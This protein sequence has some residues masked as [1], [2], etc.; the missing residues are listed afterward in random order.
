MLVPLGVKPGLGLWLLCSVIATSLVCEGSDKIKNLKRET[1]VEL[2]LVVDDSALRA[3]GAKFDI[4][5]RV[6]LAP[7]ELPQ[8]RALP[9]ERCPGK[10]LT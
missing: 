8:P 7:G 1:P 5:L 9:E 2:D 4:G 6:R 3:P 10:T